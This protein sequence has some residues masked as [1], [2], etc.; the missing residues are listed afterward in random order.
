MQKNYRRSSIPDL[1]KR[2]VPMEQINLNYMN[3]AICII[4][5]IV[6]AVLIASIYTAAAYPNSNFPST[7]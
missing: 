4:I 7:L 3:L 1:R 5:G 2:T 6:I